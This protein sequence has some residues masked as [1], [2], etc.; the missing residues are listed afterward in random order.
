MV[1]LAFIAFRKILET[2]GFRRMNL[3]PIRERLRLVGVPH[4]R[5]PAFPL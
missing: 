4:L 2:Y 1:R 5:Y 3:S